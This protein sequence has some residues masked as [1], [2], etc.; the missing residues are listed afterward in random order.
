MSRFITAEQFALVEELYSQGL[1]D[2]AIERESGVSDSVIVRW[3]R[4]RGLESNY[5]KR[6]G[7]P[8]PY[9][10]SNFEGVFNYNQHIQQWFSEVGATSPEEKRLA[11]RIAAKEM[12]RL[13]E[14]RGM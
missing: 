10:R 9:T 14:G 1:S 4:A 6:M 7:M 5:I 12:I 3:R 8:A 13:R 2:Q 11:F